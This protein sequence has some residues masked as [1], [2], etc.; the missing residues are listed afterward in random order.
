VKIRIL[1]PLLAVASLSLGGL[2]GLA[3]FAAP[4]D[5]IVSA[6]PVEGDDAP[7]AALAPA[8]D[9]GLATGIGTSP[10]VI[11]DPVDDPGAFG[12]VALDAARSGRLALLAILVLLALSRGAIWAAARWPTKLGWIGGAARPWIVGA[13]GFLATAATS[14]AT[15]GRL[16][17]SALIGAL[18]A[19]FALELR[20]APPPKAPSLGGG[21]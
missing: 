11:P 4:G 13:A 19:A 10:V 1:L 14:L 15:I 20:A 21:K 6:S 12:G 8:G 16:D 5:P 9:A 17:A 7:V 2:V 18:A 3:A